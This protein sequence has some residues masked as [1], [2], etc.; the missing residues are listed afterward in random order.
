MRRLAV[1]LV[2]LLGCRESAPAAPPWANVPAT[3]EV[4]GEDTYVT[5]QPL[6]VS[7]L[8]L[9]GAKP[10]TKDVLV[11][12]VEGAVKEVDVDRTDSGW[13]LVFEGRVPV[14]EV[15]L[16]GVKASRLRV[17]IPAGE[18]PD[19]KGA[20]PDPKTLDELGEFKVTFYWVEFE[21]T[22]AKDP[23]DTPI[24]DDEGN[25]LGRFAKK[26]VERIRIEGTGKLRDG[27]VI[28]VTGKEGRFEV[29]KCPNGLG[30]KGYHLIPFRS[31]AVDKDVVPVGTELYVP[32]AVGAKLPDGTVHDG[33]FW[34]HDVG[35][36]ID[37]KHL[38][39]FT[40][41]GDQREVLE[42]A[43]LKNLRDTR[44]YRVTR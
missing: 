20:K 10:I 36:G 11:H 33:R 16:L 38:D 1:L 5:F 42:K 34:A 12:G 35:G 18:V 17:T 25:E 28:N 6:R 40:G 7:R 4:V 19:P 39:F 9:D 41:A 31:V 27:R 14:A 44:V 2:L 32:S 13:E 24:L 26:F 22:Y 21:E 8:R 29:V 15:V 43:G 3:V 30:T 23:A 37:G